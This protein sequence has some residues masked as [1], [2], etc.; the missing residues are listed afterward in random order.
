MF[1]FEA[2]PIINWLMLLLVFTALM[3]LNEFSRRWKWAG[4]LCFLVLPLFLTFFVWPKT[5]K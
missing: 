4:F 2:Q 3:L 1:L 5:A